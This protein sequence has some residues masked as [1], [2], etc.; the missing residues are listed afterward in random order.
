MNEEKCHLEPLF[1]NLSLV[2]QNLVVLAN[3]GIIA[4]CTW[5]LLRFY[6]FMQK[7]DKEHWNQWVKLWPSLGIF[8]YFIVGL[9][10]FGDTA[11]ANIC[12]VP[13]NGTWG[14]WWLP[15]SREL[16]VQITGYCEVVVGL[17]LAISGFLNQVK[18]RQLSSLFLFFMTVGMTFANIYMV[19]HHSWIIA[20]NGRATLTIHIVRG[21]LQAVWLSNLLYMSKGDE[22]EERKEKKSK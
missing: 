16:I 20:I 2:Q 12:I 14:W 22:Y 9:T 6:D 11:I 21:L 10:H 13:P 3:A 15:V 19:T 4:A 17:A 8:P 1:P 7:K 5:V 18:I